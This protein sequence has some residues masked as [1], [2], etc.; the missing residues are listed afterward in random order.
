MRGW[1]FILVFRILIRFGRRFHLKRE[2]FKL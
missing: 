1:K 2:Q